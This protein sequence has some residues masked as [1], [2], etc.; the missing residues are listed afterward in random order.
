MQPS[1]LKN[2]NVAIIGAGYAGAAAGKALSRLGCDVKLYEQAPQIKEVGA[3][4][5]LRPSTMACFRD[6]GILDAITNVSSPSDYFQALTATGDPIIQEPW[7]EIDIHGITTHL[8]HRGDFID[9]LLGVLPPDML[10]LG[11]AAESVDDS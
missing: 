10:Q 11:H 4:I 3:G 2:L 7:P 8:I 9:A 6:W 1:D 5:G